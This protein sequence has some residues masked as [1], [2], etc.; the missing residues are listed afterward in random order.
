MAKRD[1][2]GEYDRESFL[3]CRDRCEAWEVECSDKYVDCSMH[4][5]YDERD[6]CKQTCT[7]SKPVYSDENCTNYCDGIA[8]DYFK[9][10]QDKERYI[11]SCFERCKKNGWTE[12]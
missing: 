3:K 11:Q 1:E 12:E 7:S 9:S 2:N 6:K 4:N 10:E 8:P 5:G